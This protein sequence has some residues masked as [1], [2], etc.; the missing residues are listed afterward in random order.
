M[1][2]AFQIRVEQQLSIFLD[3]RPGLLAHTC[4]ALA[5]EAINIK[6][7]SIVDTVDYVVVR[8]IV[9]RFAA[10]Q[11]I[12]SAMHPLIHVRD[13]VYIEVDTKPGVLARI[14]EKLTEAGIN[15]EYAYCTSSTAEGPGGLVLRTNDLEATIGILT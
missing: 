10:A 12:L 9:D 14:A 5:R 7:L 1:A 11:K 3:N 2:E 8:M 4:E 13:V 6:A 15:I